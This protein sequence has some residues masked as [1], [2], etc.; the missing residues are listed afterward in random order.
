MDMT[1]SGE[2]IGVPTR[3]GPIVTA[4]M[5]HR[6]FRDLRDK[7]SRRGWLRGLVS[8]NYD[9]PSKRRHGGGGILTARRRQQIRRTGQQIN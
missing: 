8:L 9:F 5:D 3:G 2:M 1:V 7:R 6:F 4:V